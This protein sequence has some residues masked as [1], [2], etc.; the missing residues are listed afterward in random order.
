M[1][2]HIEDILNAGAYGRDVC[3]NGRKL[4]EYAR[5][6]L[7]EELRIP[8]WREPVFPEDDETFVQLIGVANAI[9]FCFRDPVTKRLYETEYRGVK[10]RGAFGMF[11]ALKRAH[12]SGLAILDPHYLLQVSGVGL[13]RIFGTNPS[14]PLL[15]ERVRCLLSAGHMLHLYAGGKYKEFFQRCQYLAFNKG[16]GIV[17]RL[18]KYDPRYRDVSFYAPTSRRLVFNKRANLFLMMYQG[19]ALASG[20]KLPLIEDADDFTPPA[21]YHVPRVLRH[22]GILEYSAELSHA[23]DEGLEIPAGSQWEQEIRI[24]TVVAMSKLCEQ[25]GKSIVAMDA[26][27]WS[28][29]GFARP[30]HITTT[31]AY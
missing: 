15:H 11:A 9:N 19:R 25:S 21:D 4:T 7:G 1:N 28:H 5:R 29:H 23:V 14:M 17:E 24:Q 16:K 18:S 8:E 13:E 26:K 27:V 30:Q 2:P 22:L 6:W 20:G 12:E 3:V 10:W 31:S